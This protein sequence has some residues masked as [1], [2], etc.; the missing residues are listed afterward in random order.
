MSD[1]NMQITREF[2]ELNMFYVLPHWRHEEIARDADWS[3]A[4]LF[5]EQP[6][7]VPR[8]E[9]ECLL[10]PGDV[11]AIQRAVVEVRAWHTDRLYKSAIESTSLFA[12]VASAQ[13]RALAD[14]VFDGKEYKIVLVIS[15]F[16]L[17]PQSRVQAVQALQRLGINHVLEFPTVLAGILRLISAHANYAPSQSLQVMR[18]LKRYDF[19]RSQQ[20]EL[21]F[22]F[23]L[24]EAANPVAQTMSEP[25]VEEE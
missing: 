11:T 8:A 21:H 24:P 3:G 12:R 16:A 14:M 10:H 20:M 19:I 23:T 18:L 9:L 15:E 1:L 5:V 4:L 2:F 17:T 22:P 6:A 13:T 25:A 7:P